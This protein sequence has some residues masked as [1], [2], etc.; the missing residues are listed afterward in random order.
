MKLH[1]IGGA[2]SPHDGANPSRRAIYRSPWKAFTADYGEIA[3]TG[4][5]ASCGVHSSE[6]LKSQCRERNCLG[7][8]MEKGESTF[9]YPSLVVCDSAISFTDSSRTLLPCEMP[10]RASRTMVVDPMLA[11]GTIGDDAD[12]LDE[13]YIPAPR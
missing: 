6:C 1:E 5:V 7:V 2:V 10:R 3:V 12:T 11:S 8:E 9:K 13:I 4:L